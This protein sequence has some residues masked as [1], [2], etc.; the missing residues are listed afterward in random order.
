[1]VR[2]TSTG[3]NPTSTV[4]SSKG[5]P[6]H[7]LKQI[8]MAQG[9]EAPDSRLPPLNNKTAKMH[10][11]VQLLQ[12]SKLGLG[13]THLSDTLGVVERTIKRYL[14][15]IRRLRF[16][17]V[18]EQGTRRKLLYRIMRGAA[19][20]RH[21]LPALKKI[22][23]ELHAGGN[24]KY[25][26]LIAQLIKFLE[27]KEND[28]EPSMDLENLPVGPDTYYIHHGPFAEADPIPGTLKR[29][30]QA[31]TNRSIVRIVYSGLNHG[32]EEYRFYPYALS[33]RVGTLYLIGHQGKNDGPFKSLSVK[34]IHRCIS[35]KE[36]FERKAFSPAE[37]YKYC[38]GQWARQAEEIPET[39]LLALKA[40]WLEKFLSESHFDP[41]GKIKRVGKEV[42]FELKLVIKPDFINWILSLTPDLIPI[43]PESLR[44]DV[45]ERLLKGLALLPLGPN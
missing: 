30:E 22:S 18:S 21:F 17:L 20:P 19:T 4:T 3:I 38:F 8:R 39:I 27:E 12:E 34:R 23:T 44:R 26:A 2:E 13:I 45:Q 43:K 31:I 25:T 24:P 36:S 37:Y 9:L 40:P 41:P 11:M 15:D 28:Q 42:Q 35:T 10:K 16:D 32:S 29:L 7:I 14:S 5:E 6:L 33:L 1:M